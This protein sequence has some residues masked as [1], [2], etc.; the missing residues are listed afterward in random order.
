MSE[1]VIKI[2]ALQHV[3]VLKKPSLLTSQ[4]FTVLPLC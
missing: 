4:T 3:E 1:T 2:D